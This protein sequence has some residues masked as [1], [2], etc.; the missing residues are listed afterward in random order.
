[1]KKIILVH[2]WAGNP[3]NHWFPFLKKEIKKQGSKVIVP[4]MPGSDTPEINA[5]VGF[6]EEVIEN[7]GGLDEDTYLIGH[8]IGCQTIMRYLQEADR[9]CGGVIFVAPW[10]N[11]P[12]L[13]TEEERQI[14]EPW[15][16]ENI[17]FKIVRENVKKIVCIFSDNDPDVPLSDSEIFKEK[18]GAKIIVEA[19]KGHFTEDAGII[20]LPVVIDELIKMS[21]GRD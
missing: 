1:M 3:E 13:G 21:D 7:K 19:G 2:G 12:Y 4:K 9:R 17:D 15:L 5:W 6:L 8:S 10:F 11:L 16:E 20:E 18:L 14:A